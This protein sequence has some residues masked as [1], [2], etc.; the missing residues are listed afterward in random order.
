MV[1]VTKGLFGRKFTINS[2]GLKRV[3][4]LFFT[5]SDSLLLQS[6]L[7]LFSWYPFD[8]SD[9]C[10]FNPDLLVNTF[11][12]NRRMR[13]YT[14]IQVLTHK[15]THPTDCWQCGP[16]FSAK[17]AVGGSSGSSVPLMMYVQLKM[18]AQHNECFSRC[19]CVSYNRGEVKVN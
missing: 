18:P 16:R 12:A 1:Y 17:T 15:Y 3:Q 19:E 13:L 2:R 14:H 5:F 9:I 11:C 8:A 10:V 6:F 4:T 7:P